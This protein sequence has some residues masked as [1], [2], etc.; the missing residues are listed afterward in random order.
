VDSVEA[1]LSRPRPIALQHHAAVAKNTSAPVKIKR[2]RYPSRISR[3]VTNLGMVY[4]ASR[5]ASGNLYT[6]DSQ[7][8]RR[9]QFTHFSS[10]RNRSGESPSGIPHKRF[11]RSLYPASISI[12]KVDQSATCC[13][14]LSNA[15]SD[16]PILEILALYFFL[17]WIMIAWSRIKI[18]SRTK[19]SIFSRARQA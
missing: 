16:F 9:R 4:F 3:F 2:L 17:I 5:R 19:P 12:I 6:L 7:I 14:I 13:W 11:P 1:A 18:L 10:P 15:L 8:I